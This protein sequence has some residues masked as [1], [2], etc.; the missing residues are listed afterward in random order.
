MYL[1]VTT[2]SEN[3]TSDEYFDKKR[4]AR[5]LYIRIKETKRTLGLG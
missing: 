5:F 2:L 4:D 3:V 1:I